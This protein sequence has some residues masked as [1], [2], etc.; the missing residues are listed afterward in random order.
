[1]TE[2]IHCPYCGKAGL[3][4]LY[5]TVFRC[6]GCKFIH[7]IDKM[8]WDEYI[9]YESSINHKEEREKIENLTKI[10]DAAAKFYELDENEIMNYKK[11]L[12]EA[13]INIKDVLGLYNKIK[14]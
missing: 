7:R 14:E 8:S 1:M 12:Q 3:Q 5:G 9:Q 10:K 4:K 6:T 13:I 2:I 11:Q